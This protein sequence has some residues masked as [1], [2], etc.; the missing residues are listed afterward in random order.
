ML[1]D[2]S[3]SIHAALEID[4]DEN[5]DN[6]EIGNAIEG[7]HGDDEIDGDYVNE[8]VD[9]SQLSS[10]E[11]NQVNESIDVHWMSEDT[12]MLPILVFSGV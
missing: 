8:A 5:E 4:D 1:L 6:E 2:A 3:H 7:D 10:N 11:E 9:I 12:W